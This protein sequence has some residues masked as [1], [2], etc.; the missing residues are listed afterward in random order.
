MP[1]QAWSRRQN[2]GF[3]GWSCPRPHVWGSRTA[4]NTLRWAATGHEHLG[5]PATLE[6]QGDS[7]RHV[8]CFFCVLFA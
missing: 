7:C 3:D 6:V 4:G 1:G 2:M 8:A 5:R